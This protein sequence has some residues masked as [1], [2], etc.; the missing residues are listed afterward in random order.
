MPQL[1]FEEEGVAVLPPAELPRRRPGFVRRMAAGAWHLLSGFWFLLRRPSFWPLA[2][3]PTLLAVVCVL[4]GIALGAFAIPWLE[5]HVLPGRG[6]VAADLV[7]ERVR[8][9]AASPARK[10]RRSVMRGD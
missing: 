5:T 1:P 9:G 2:A 8:R 3:L 6:K 10:L 4:S 7:C